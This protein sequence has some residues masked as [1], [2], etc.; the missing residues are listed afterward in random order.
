MTQAV[1]TF[2]LNLPNAFADLDPLIAFLKEGATHPVEIDCKGVDFLPAR[3]VQ[4]LLAAHSHWSALER[5]FVLAG[6]TES[7]ARQLKL[8]GVSEDRFANKDAQ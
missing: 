2:E 3:C 4:I 5:G 6:M 8:M 7:C 1:R